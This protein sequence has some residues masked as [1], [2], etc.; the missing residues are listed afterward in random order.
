MPSRPLFYFRRFYSFLFILEPVNP[1][2][3]RIVEYAAVM[4]GNIIIRPF[5]DDVSAVLT[6]HTGFDAWLDAERGN[7]GPY[8]VN[9]THFD[10]SNLAPWFQDTQASQLRH[11]WF[12]VHL[13]VFHGP[14]L[15]GLEA[16]YH[17]PPWRNEPERGVTPNDLF[18]SMTG[19][20]LGNLLNTIHQGFW[21]MML[22]CFKNHISDCFVT[23][24]S[25]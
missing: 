17:D 7:Y 2:L 6:G 20:L 8:F 13:T 5:V 23:S 18:L 3:A 21:R 25:V 10:Q 1:L 16:V 4:H 24:Q 11:F 22:S 12:S 19:I 15:A 14:G 9:P